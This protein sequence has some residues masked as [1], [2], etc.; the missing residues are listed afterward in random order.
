[1]WQAG[2]RAPYILTHLDKAR[3][4]SRDA[5]PHLELS[6]PNISSV[7]LLLM[8][9]FT[10]ELWNCNLLRNSKW[11]LHRKCPHLITYGRSC[12]KEPPGGRG[13]AP[14]GWEEAR[15]AAQWEPR[16]SCGASQAKGRLQESGPQGLVSPSRGG[17]AA[18]LECP[19]SVPPV[20]LT[21]RGMAGGH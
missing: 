21:R 20:H 1:M 4:V 14:C 15:P 3:T 7:I 2:C 19:P 10:F 13:D 18:I 6:F 16:P 9:F 8:S 12:T 11:N 5:F 17:S